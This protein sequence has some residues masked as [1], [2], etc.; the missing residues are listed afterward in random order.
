MRPHA[1]YHIGDRTFSYDANGNQTGWEHDKNGTRRQILWDDENRIQKIGDP[2]NTLE[3]A[4]DD[5]GERVVKRGQHGMTVYIN[6]YFTVRNLAL[7]SKHIFAGA[8]RIATKVEPGEPVG[9][10]EEPLPT[11]SS[12]TT[13]TTDTTGGGETT[14][15]TTEE[16]GLVDKALDFLGLGTWKKEG[17]H[18]GQGLEHRSD[19]ANEV[20]QNTVKNP[21][22]TGHRPEKGRLSDKP[23]N[24][25]GGNGNGNAEKSNNGG[26]DAQ[27]CANAAG[28]GCAGAANTDKS[29][30][31]NGGGST[32]DGINGGGKKAP[33]DYGGTFLYFYHPDHLA[34]PP[35]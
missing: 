33:Y 11:D 6:Q 20:A 23:G 26:G 29:N 17:G 5:A 12:G 25:A 32:V 19:R 7:A 28:A 9:Y 16:P 31:G 10:K 18:P 24:N 1:P 21:N 15:T 14:T 34:A 35:T 13:T 2:S 22:L 4:Y 27:G 30:N 8:T 3:F